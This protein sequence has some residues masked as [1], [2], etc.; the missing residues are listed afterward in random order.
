MK[1]TKIMKIETDS[2]RNRNLDI[3]IKSKAIEVVIK[4]LSIKKSL[5]LHTFTQGIYQAF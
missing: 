1:Y 3:Q 2:R 5:G 4:N